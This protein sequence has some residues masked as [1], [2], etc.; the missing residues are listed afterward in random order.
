MFYECIARRWI[1][2]QMRVKGDN[3]SWKGGQGQQKEFSDGF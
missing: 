1:K 2:A 3:R